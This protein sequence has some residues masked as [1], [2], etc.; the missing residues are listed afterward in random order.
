MHAASPAS[1]WR[2]VKQPPPHRTITRRPDDPKLEIGDKI[3]MEEGIV[4]VALARYTRSGDPRHDVHYI[5][6]L[7][8]EAQEH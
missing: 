7:R 5:V 4:G 3:P 6:E 2:R 8:Q 1:K